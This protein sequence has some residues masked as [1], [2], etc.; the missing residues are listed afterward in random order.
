[1]KRKSFDNMA[2]V[3]VDGSSKGNPGPAGI[4][5]FVLGE[6]GRM[7][8]RGGEFIG[9]ATS[10]VAEYYALKEGMEQALELGLLSVK[11]MSDSLMVVNQMKGIF[12]IGNKDILPIYYDIRQMMKEFKRVKFVHV[13]RSKNTA[14]DKEARLAISRHIDEKMLK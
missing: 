2:T 11:F 10:R 14:A 13:S 9:F 12:R 1:M 4:G 5:Y 8:K 6:D 7:L 3:Y